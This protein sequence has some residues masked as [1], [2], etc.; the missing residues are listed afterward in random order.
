MP[1]HPTCDPHGLQKQSV[2]AARTLFVLA[3]ATR[4]SRTASSPTFP[5]F[6]TSVVKYNKKK[7]VIQLVYGSYE[8]HEKANARLSAGVGTDKD[9]QLAAEMAKQTGSHGDAAR[10]ALRKSGRSS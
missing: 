5:D 7:V 4:G 10:E 3:A 8:D 6:A 2:F 1:P 9:A